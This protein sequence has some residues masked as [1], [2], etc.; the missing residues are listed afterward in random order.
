MFRPTFKTLQIVAVTAITSLATHAL[1]QQG[2][3]RRG[4]FSSMMSAGGMDPD[5]LLRDL[6]RFQIALDLTDEQVMLVE[7]FLRDYDE[8]FRE[9]SD[10]SQES[11]GNSFS[12]MRGNQDSPEQQRRNELR[13]RSRE[14]RDK[15]DSAKKLGDEDG[16]KDLQERLQTEL[17]N[18]REEMNT[19][20]TE[21]W[22]SPE[23]QAA[24]EE[25]ALLMQDQLRLKRKMRLEFES[26]LVIVLTED[27]Q[28]LWPPLQ[29]QLI[30]DRLLPRGRLSGETTDLMSFVDQ[31]DY[32]DETLTTILP[33]LSE[34]DLSVTP[35]LT[36]RD[37]HMIENQGALMSSM[38]SLDSASSLDIMKAQGK[39]AENVRDINSSAIENIVILLPQEEGVAFD[40]FAKERAYPR[41]Y[42][43]T[44]TDRAYQ[45]AMEL[46]GLEADIL[47]AINELY[48]GLQSE[49]VYANEQ[50]LEATHRWESQE[51]LDR[52]NRFAERMS[53]GSSERAES[54]IQKAE[55]AKRVIEENYLEQ[56]RMLLTEE[57]I[58]A[59]GGLK[60]REERSSGD[61]RDRGGE[62]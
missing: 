40:S 16:M 61:W 55:E 26:D 42:R 44:R 32:S 14:I 30:R 4:G 20:R 46:E 38:S 58:E 60:K 22:Q 37:E 2:S 57:Q 1:A 27:Q 18:I 13:E 47:Q 10:A 19:A 3:G 17:E 43:P 21:Q 15:L 24:F 54:P 49:M 25:V 34:W 48:V 52:M 41:I 45:A 62:G 9:A 59:L 6:Q 36:A 56:L 50:L 11:V 12:S 53:G 7:Q 39:L 35:A 28:L 29:R 33:V 31:Q 23:R 8:S 51:R 5:Y